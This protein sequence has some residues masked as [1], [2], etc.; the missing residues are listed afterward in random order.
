MRRRVARLIPVSHVVR[1]SER[2]G[3]QSGS[4]RRA[5]CR[6]T[7]SASTQR[8]GHHTGHS[9]AW[10]CR[11][12]RSREA[13]DDVGVTDSVDNR[14][15][16]EIAAKAPPDA[17]RSSAK[18]ASPRLHRRAHH[19][20]HVAER[21]RGDGLERGAST[22]ID[23]REQHSRHRGRDR[24]PEPL[25]SVAQAEH[26]RAQHDSEHKTRTPQ[27]FLEARDDKN[28]LEFF[29]HTASEDPDRQPGEQ[30]PRLLEEDEDRRSA[31]RRR[32]SSELITEPS[33]TFN[34]TN[35]AR[36]RSKPTPRCFGHS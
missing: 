33:P 1:Q 13:P 8:S 6:R 14:H 30:V 4:C 15:D 24:D 17:D 10:G 34:A 22:Q 25:V 32:G 27:P 28:P 5:P 26:Y 18:G 36:P 11:S 3:Q 2:S 35:I 19:R 7:G 31:Y 20:E 21:M 9:S 12:A 29:H 16:P 23:E